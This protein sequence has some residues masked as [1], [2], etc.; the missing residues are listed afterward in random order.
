ME[1]EVPLFF[2]A[3]KDEHREN[4]TGRDLDEIQSTDSDFRKKGIHLSLQSKP[5][6][7]LGSR[8][9]LIAYLGMRQTTD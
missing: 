2:Y 7:S 5:N 8:G 3:E 4:E 1:S 6:Q 9:K